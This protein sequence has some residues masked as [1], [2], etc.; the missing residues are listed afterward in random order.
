MNE[1]V[2]GQPTHFRGGLAI[3]II[4]MFTNAAGCSRT[5]PQ[6]AEA[7]AQ[8]RVEVTVVD[9]AAFDAILAGLRGKV[10]LVDCWATWCTPCLEQLPHSGEL[11]E[12]HGDSGLAVVT[13]SLDDPDKL[14]Q[15]RSALGA[16]VSEQVRHLVSEFGGG[17]T[18]VEV[19]E[20]PGGALPHYKL[21]DRS[22]NLRR[23]F[24]LDPSAQGQFTPAD[25][26]KAVAELLAE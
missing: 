16:I 25:V 4:A 23:T 22:G 24:Q 8:D 9:R 15:I 10:V 18:S 5:E 3:C 11:A 17:S 21:Y 2:P 12:R 20:I 26:D 7:S 13:L 1:A 6:S 19:F 14:P